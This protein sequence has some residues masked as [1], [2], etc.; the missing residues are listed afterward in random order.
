MWRTRPHC[1]S[2]PYANSTKF[3]PSAPIKIECNSKTGEMSPP[4]SPNCVWAAWADQ[5]VCTW[6][7]FLMASQAELGSTI[8]LVQPGTDAPRPQGWRSTKL[9]QYN[10]SRVTSECVRILVKVSLQMSVSSHTINHHFWLANIQDPCIIGLDFLSKNWLG[11]S[12]IHLQKA[13][14]ASQSHAVQDCTLVPQLP[15]PL[16]AYGQAGCSWTKDQRKRQR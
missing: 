3:S 5:M 9:Y 8:L 6:T 7:V 13:G 11:N 14:T 16:S 15:S 12:L 4:K 10:F 2:L 1:T